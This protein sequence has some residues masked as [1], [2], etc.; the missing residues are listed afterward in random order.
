MAFP[1]V[2][3]P[4]RTP[5]PAEPGSLTERNT[6]KVAGRSPCAAAWPAYKE[7]PPWTSG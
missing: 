7:R 6:V 4:M 5:A 3:C 2:R 1:S